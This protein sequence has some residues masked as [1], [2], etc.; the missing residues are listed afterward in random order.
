WAGVRVRAETEAPL[1]VTP[2]STTG[3]IRIDAPWR[4]HPR[5]RRRRPA[6][7]PGPLVPGHRWCSRHQL[8]LGTSARVARVQPR[9]GAVTFVDA[10]AYRIALRW[11]IARPRTRAASNSVARSDAS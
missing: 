5:R 3:C 10:R 8:G 6:P 7:G 2:P 9:T 11:D 1:M 4:H